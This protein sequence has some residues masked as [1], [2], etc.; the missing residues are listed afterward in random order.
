MGGQH[1]ARVV[2][3]IGDAGHDVHVLPHQVGVEGMDVGTESVD[4]G[5]ERLP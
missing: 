5:G 1:V 4:V 3:A 2:Q